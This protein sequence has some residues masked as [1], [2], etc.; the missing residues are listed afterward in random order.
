MGPRCL[1]VA[2][3]CGSVASDVRQEQE[4]EVCEGKPGD[5]KQAFTDT[6][7]DGYFDHDRDPTTPCEPLL[8]QNVARLEAIGGRLGE[9]GD[10]APLFFGVTSIQA[11]LEQVR[12]LVLAGGIAVVQRDT[13]APGGDTAATLAAGRVLVDAMV[14]TAALGDGSTTVVSPRD[15]M[16]VVRARTEIVSGLG[17]LLQLWCRDHIDILL[18]Q[19]KRPMM[20]DEQRAEAQSGKGMMLKARS[21]GELYG[22]M[23]PGCPSAR[24]EDNPRGRWALA[25]S[26][27]VEAA[28]QLPSMGTLYVRRKQRATI[29][30]HGERWAP[31]ELLMKQINERRFHINEGGRLKLIR[32]VVQDSALSSVGH[33]AAILVDLGA[34]LHVV[35]SRPCAIRTVYVC[36]SYTGMGACRQGPTSWQILRAAVAAPSPSRAPH[37]STGVNLVPTSLSRAV[38]VFLSDM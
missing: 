2:L 23:C 28:V 14:A 17:Q 20:S 22:W 36:V 13:I 11:Q 30:G 27:K 19:P 12:A 35:S 8:D 31:P 5:E 18:P 1:L 32:L 37:I 26:K 34:T 16:R 7:G 21:M 15:H 10:F 24:G 38:L 4:E 9:L 3:A 6:C 33:G 29:D 25:I